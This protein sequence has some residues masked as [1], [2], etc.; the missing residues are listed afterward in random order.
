MLYLLISRRNLLFLFVIFIWFLHKGEVLWVLFNW[1]FV[2]L[3]LWLVEKWILE[4]LSAITVLYRG[5]FAVVR[6]QPSWL[7]LLNLLILRVFYLLVVLKGISFTLI[8]FIERVISRLLWF[9]ILIFEDG[10]CWFMYISVLFVDTLVEVEC[11]SG[12]VRLLEFCGTKVF[13][14]FFLFLFFAFL[15][16][17]VSESVQLV[18]IFPFLLHL[19]PLFFFLCFS[20]AQRVTQVV[21]VEDLWARGRW[22]L[23]LR[24]WVWVTGL[25]LGTFLSLSFQVVFQLLV[26]L[27][28]REIGT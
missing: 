26:C 27:L 28:S 16:T 19:H 7:P 15:V 22:I 5:L 2:V 3:L 9:S 24:W 23:N 17:I 8:N 12:Q 14:H 1:F 20:L 11:W 6:S 10:L 18:V 13:G 25:F 4:R 21:N